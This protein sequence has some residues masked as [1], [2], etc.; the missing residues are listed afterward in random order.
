SF[1]QP[2]LRRCLFGPETINWCAMVVYG[3]EGCVFKILFGSKVP[4]AVKIHSVPHPT[5]SGKGPSWPFQDECR[6]AA[7]LEQM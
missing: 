3:F 5:P 4:F 1:K 2:A 7:V 6:T